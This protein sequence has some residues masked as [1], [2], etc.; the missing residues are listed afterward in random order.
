MKKTSPFFSL[1]FLFFTFNTI[2][3]DL[4]SP[5]EFLGKPTGARFNFHHKIIEYVNY[6]AQIR[7]LTTKFIS[8]GTTTEGRPMVILA[9]GNANNIAKLEEIRTSNLKNIGLLNGSS[10]KN[11]PSIAMFSYNVH[12]NE[13]VNAETSINVIYE[14][15]NGKSEKANKILSNTIV[16]VDPCVNPDGFDRYSQWYNRYVGK[17]PDLNNASIEHNE[18]W[19]GGRY[20]HYLFDMNRD[21]AWQTQVETQQRI[22][23]F[24][25]WMPH[26]HAD[27]HEM[28]PNST[29]YFP[30]SARPFHEDLTSYQR[31]FQELLGQYNK[32]IFDDKGW[33]YFTK[34]NYDLFYPSYGDTYPSY[35]GAIAM[36]FEQAG[37]AGGAAGVSYLRVDGDTL[38][39]KDRITH[40]FNT[41]MATLE[42]ISDKSQKT[43]EEFI[44]YFEDTNKKGFGKYKSFVI[45]NESN[46]SKIKELVNH[47]ERLQ[48]NYSFADKKAI[49]SGYNYSNQKE[50]S[51]SVE[52]KDLIINT[53][54][55]KGVLTKIL[56]EP[57][58]VLE[59]SNTYDIT[60]WALPYAYGLKA[61]ATSQKLQ[62]IPATPDIPK[63]KLEPN[64][65]VYAFAIKY[66]AFEAAKLLAT[67]LKE[68]VKVRVHESGFKAEGQLF[69]NG[70]LLITRKGNE[71]LG[72]NFEKKMMSIL[73]NHAEKVV[74]LY[75]GMVESGSD[76]GASVVQPILPPTVGIIMGSGVS[77]TAAGDVWHY[78]EQ[79]LNYPATIIDGSYFGKIELN[80]F[81]VLI[82]P[83]GKYSNIVKDHK[84]LLS[85]VS[86]GGRLILLEGANNY[87]AGKEGF[88]LK[89]KINLDKD[90][91]DP[92]KIYGT[93]ERASISDQIPGAIFKVNLDDTHP[94]AYGYDKEM[95]ILLKN[96]YDFEMLKEGWNVGKI[97]NNNLISGFVGKNA[98]EKL[99]N[100]PIFSVQEHDKG[101]IIYLIESPIFRGFWYG[102]K[103]LFANA[104]FMVN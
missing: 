59:D 79:Q 81:D 49:S 101:K 23:F 52:P 94:L 15:A 64:K 73:E 39:L 17:I 72:D 86:N 29:Y 46:T 100:I 30:P 102:G 71:N 16:L 21:L 99:K 91:T 58:T 19:P 28:G 24:N 93:R 9:I 13:A 96:V 1:L 7:P 70:T 74:P 92:D 83:T 32:K 33:L 95:H 3:Q 90:K 77:A 44:R 87:F 5:Q 45:K 40:S 98:K 88:T 26:L 60:A 78:F 2:A 85:W 75:S 55:P 42:A 50:E 89:T 20:N 67:L 69:G 11:I 103:L 68:K 38:T 57:S 48:I 47:L 61:Y 41:S 53:F 10:N 43:T 84:D 66:D 51:F 35:N 54:Q 34:E 82:F 63:I 18:P 25:S 4:K 62:G 12:G 27:F 80:K 14:L 56:F 76:L 6:V 36:T 97:A 8:Y 104:V 65:K 22:K 37:G 31:E